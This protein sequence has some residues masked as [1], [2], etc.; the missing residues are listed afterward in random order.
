MVDRS[1]AEVERWLR[2]H[3]ATD[4]SAIGLAIAPGVGIGV[5]TAG[6]SAG[7]AAL[8]PVSVVV[9]VDA[10][11]RPRWVWWDRATADPLAAAGVPIARC[12]DVLTVHR[13][14]HGGWRTS[15]A[16]VWAWLQGLPASS[17][18]AMG[19]LG[20]LD[21]HGDEGDDPEDPVRP[22]RHLR[23]EWASGGWAANPDRLGV[24]A[25][26]ALD[27]MSLQHDRIAASP[28]AEPGRV[29]STARSESAAEF[30]CAELTVDGLPIDVAE[31]E[32]IIAEAIG[33][34][35]RGEAD[36]AARR[37]ERD[38]VVLAQAPAGRA[39]DLR[40]PG[41]VKGMLRRVGV[42]V[43]DTRAWRLEQHRTAHPLVEALLV[44]RK[45]ERIATTY[46]YRWLDEHVV[47][48]RLRGDWSS[49]DGAAGRMTA[50]SGLHNL[51]SELRPAVAAEPG[52]VF[53][54]A[55][56]GQIEPRVL[57]AVSG[58]AAL[59]AATQADDLYRPVATRLGVERDVAKVAVLGAMYGATTGTSAQALHGLEREY[60]T[61]M[62]VLAAA[63]AT[64]RDGADVFT[65]GGRRVR[66]WVDERTDD[67]GVGDIDRARSVAAARG[68]FARNALIQGAA[69]EFFKVWAVTVRA[70]GRTLGGRVVLCLHDELIVHVPEAHGH[71]MAAVL[72]DALAEAAYRWAPARSDGAVRFVADVSVIHR[73]SEAK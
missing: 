17:L 25:R 7:F 53:V 73:W 26:L 31:A 12:W 59:I 20:L 10:A 30:L 67:A 60:P 29:M 34:R 32:R 24:W 54:R 23:P 43:P 42:D 11:L 68:R 44:W 55:D 65:I 6:R 56:L 64:G 52:F 8:D 50:S 16:H 70:R 57:A 18:P 5:A 49:C 13:L 41:D 38:A 36:A 2:E 1:A 61:A 39:V 21:D 45:A 3:G 63:A 15:I 62:G 51:P 69:A 40:N 22:D 9:A 14:L 72:V 48:G 28:T 33:S 4:G 37:L 71:E 27:A 58:D 19:Q 46:G 47:G 66:M 35:P